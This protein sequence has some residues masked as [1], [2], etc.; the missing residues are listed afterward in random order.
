[1]SLSDDINLIP[2]DK[3]NSNWIVMGASGKSMDNRHD[4]LNFDEDTKK[5]MHL[6]E[7]KQ[8]IQVVLTKPCVIGVPEAMPLIRR[9]SLLNSQ[10]PQFLNMRRGMT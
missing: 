9:I 10:E 5:K 3:E 4:H 6:T 7:K 8:S 1:V 2:K